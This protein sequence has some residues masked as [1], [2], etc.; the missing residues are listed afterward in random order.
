MC[1]EL[2]GDFFP[3]Q[4][5]ISVRGAV[6]DVLH[7]SKKKEASHA[8]VGHAERRMDWRE[9]LAEQDSESIV[10]SV[11]MSLGGAADPLCHYVFV[12]LYSAEP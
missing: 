8:M 5:R 11:M 1:E 6:Q 7:S 3:W 9:Q 12:L 4:L 2:A 10:G